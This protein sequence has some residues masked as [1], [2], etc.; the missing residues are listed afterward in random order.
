MAEGQLR[1]PVDTCL[2]EFAKL[3]R[4]LGLKPRS[5]ERVLQEYAVSARKL[6]GEKLSL[7]DFALHLDLPVSDM[8]RE[9]FALFSEHEDNTMDIREFVIALSVVCRPAKTLETMKLAFKMFEGEQD[10]AITEAELAVILKTALGVADLSVSHL[11]AAMDTADTGKITFDTFRSFV[12][13]HPDFAEDYLYG[14]NESLHSCPH[15]SHNHQHPQQQQQTTTT[16]TPRSQAPPPL[17]RGGPP[18]H[19]PR[20]Q[21][22]QRHLPRLQSQRPQQLD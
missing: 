19:G 9:M 14:D 20:Q 16:T 21:D 4:K 15:Y 18:G 13:Q 8:L 12:A 1:L 6:E 11:F 10:G 22:S 5:A 3:V 17:R 2:L 7:D